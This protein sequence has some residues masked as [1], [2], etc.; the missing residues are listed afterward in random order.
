[1]LEDAA[2]L[3][4]SLV[5]AHE[6]GQAQAV[7]DL[8]HALARELAEVISKPE[9]PADLLPAFAPVLRV[10]LLDAGDA[11]LSKVA[12]FSLE[13]A[14]TGVISQLSRIF[15]E[16]HA[17]LSDLFA[18]MS[19]ELEKG[20]VRRLEDALEWCGRALLCRI[21]AL[22]LVHEKTAESHCHLGRLYARLG[23][24]DQARKELLICRG[25]Y[26]KIAGAYE[27][28]EVAECDYR[29]GEI[30]LAAFNSPAAYQSFYQCH[31]VRFELLGRSHP[32][33]LEAERKLTEC[34]HVNGERHISSFE[35]RDRVGELKWG[36]C[37]AAS[38]EYTIFI[39][40]GSLQ[41]K[42]NYCLTRSQ[43]K[44]LARTA[45]KYSLA[46]RNGSAAS[47]PSFYPGMT[48]A[49]PESPTSTKSNDSLLTEDN[50]NRLLA[51]LL[52][53]DWAPSSTVSIPPSPAQRGGSPS[54]S[55]ASKDIDAVVETQSSLPSMASLASTALL[56]DKSRP[57]SPSLEI[58]RSTEVAVPTVHSLVQQQTDPVPPGP[59]PVLKVSS[60]AATSTDYHSAESKEIERST[61]PSPSL[62]SDS[63]SLP[64]LPHK[65]PSKPDRR[66][67][68]QSARL[69]VIN[70][71]EGDEVLP[72]CMGDRSRFVAKDRDG[73][74][75]LVQL[76]SVAGS[77]KDALSAPPLVQETIM[78]VPEIKSAVALPI[79]TPP[80][81]PTS[82]PPV[83]VKLSVE[84]CILA[85]DAMNGKHSSSS[86]GAAQIAGEGTD[87][88]SDLARKSALLKATCPHIVVES[89][90]S[91]AGTIWERESE[92]VVP[93]EEVF[94]DFEREFV[95]A[96]P[97][98]AVEKAVLTG[99]KI[100]VPAPK[101]KV[102]QLDTVVHGNRL[103]SL[104]LM[105]YKL[106]KDLSID[107]I[108]T[109]VAELDTESL[110]PSS[111]QSLTQVPLPSSDE[112]FLVRE[113]IQKSN[114]IDLSDT[115]L[116]SK[117]GQAQ[118]YIMKL[119]QIANYQVRVNFIL[120]HHVIF[121]EKI[122][123][124]VQTSAETMLTAIRDIRGSH[125]LKYLLLSI[126]QLSNAVNAKSLNA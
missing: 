90:A 22:G 48:P 61:S 97:P 82:W 124:A 19:L 55:R 91:V 89:L 99:K 107:D 49:L 112:V 34:R 64:I 24:L 36:K 15:G 56:E 81:L 59:K 44:S 52:Q 28:I 39:F 114:L 126:L 109:A 29:V 2:S 14:Q 71:I 72:F 123:D 74:S 27:S 25:I 92:A 32:L 76:L 69:A 106:G 111:V 84:N 125:R 105:L 9:S 54:S 26:S 13:R 86:T 57:S 11:Q 118:Y 35:V 100:A 79:P 42:S 46:R 65:S 45:E 83:S 30:E 41:G 102:H 120:A 37:D 87:E 121:R 1:M 8:G 50:V 80:P 113:L 43:L 116:L 101:A 70:S 110:D 5:E 10:M 40:L 95:L 108:V 16:S 98:R 67:A 47:L 7:H 93:W 60:G 104:D 58:I 63:A 78:I 119:A 18:S 31:R 115:Q 68:R 88:A 4:A 51:L 20:P 3:V 38:A 12:R 77:D 73:V 6:S 21:K 62:L 53:E 23:N 85:L 33:T 66:A 96:P 103:Q 17:F 94:S 117:L 75:V 122:G